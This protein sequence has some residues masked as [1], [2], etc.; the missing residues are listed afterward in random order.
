MSENKKVN[1]KISDYIIKNT[2]KDLESFI[3]KNLMNG[4]KMHERTE[5]PLPNRQII[6]CKIEHRRC[7]EGYETV[8]DCEEINSNEYNPSYYD[9]WDYVENLIIK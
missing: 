6:V 3:I 4:V 9:K 2:M 8:E 7:E 1:K 5:R